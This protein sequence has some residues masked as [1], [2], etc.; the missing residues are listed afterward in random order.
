MNESLQ[1]TFRTSHEKNR[2]ITIVNPRNNLAAP[3]V[4]S[5]ANMF[6]SANPFDAKVGE[7]V[8]FVR[9]QHVSVV[10]K[11]IIAPPVAA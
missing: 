9:A 1:M 11:Q 6:I 2:V 4:N 10:R 5:V 7:L 3:T 8:S